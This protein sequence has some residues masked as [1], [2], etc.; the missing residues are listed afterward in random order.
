MKCNATD[1]VRHGRITIIGFGQAAIRTIIYGRYIF[2]ISE[3]II[4]FLDRI[5]A[6]V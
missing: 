5:N 1:V 2:G 4:S 6:S 3:E